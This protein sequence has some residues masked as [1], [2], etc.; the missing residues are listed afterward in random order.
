M[1]PFT[2]QAAPSVAAAPAE[3]QIHEVMTGLRAALAALIDQLPSPIERAADLERALS[4]DS[5]LAWR[6]FRIARAVDPAEAVAHLP[7]VNQLRRAVT[8]AAALAPGEVAQRAVAAVER[9]DEL[10]STL[11]GDQ[12]GFESLVSA[13]SPGGVRRVEVQHRRAA[14]RANTHL[15]GMH[16]RRLSLM[17][18]V[19]PA[20]EPGDFDGYFVHGYHDIR[21]TRPG[22]PLV[23]RSKLQANT[24]RTVTAREE[25]P[26]VSTDTDY[27]D[28]FSTMPRPALDVREVGNGFVETH[29][30]FRGV[31]PADAETIVV[32][33]AVAHAFDPAE[34]ECDLKMFVSWPCE[35]LHA[36]VA[37]PVGL[38]DPSAVRVEAFANRDD[39]R[40]AFELR[41][42][43][44]CPIHETPTVHTAVERPAASVGHPRLR[45]I[46]DEVVRP[47][48]WDRTRYDVYRV[49]VAFPMLH[50]LVRLVMKPRGATVRG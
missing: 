27:L 22:L 46:F 42:D 9:L 10:A 18:V 29:I 23:L 41:P 19:H 25:A 6:L 3:S 16:V 36:D 44:R 45:E 24:A 48:G 5:P 34:P 28:A 15:W 1:P 2:A 11:G 39:P 26:R 14:F 37:I 21:P 47:R 49:Q 32:G 33:R 4:V 35:T 38:T 8:Q 12:R 40:R 17:V 50:S 30:Q 20:A 7:T 43:D 31:S 13:L